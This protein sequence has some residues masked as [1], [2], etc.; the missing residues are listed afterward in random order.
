[1]APDRVVAGILVR[2]GRVLLGHRH[3]SRR[4]FPACW[5]FPGGHVEHGEAGPAALRRELREELGITAAVD[6]RPADARLADGVYDC[7]FWVVRTWAGE[8]TNRAPHEHTELG[9]FALQE[10]PRLTLADG[11]YPAML[12][13]FLAER[14]EPQTT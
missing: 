12:A 3:P 4:W 10:L 6:D 2:D 9:W 5:D 8:A 11:R 13:R 7:R 1:M 14:P